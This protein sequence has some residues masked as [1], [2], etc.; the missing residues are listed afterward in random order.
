VSV[1]RIVADWNHAD[2]PQHRFDEVDELLQRAAATAR[3]RRA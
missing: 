1:R 2:G 3:M